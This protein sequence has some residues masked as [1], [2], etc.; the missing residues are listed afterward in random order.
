ME[1]DQGT[2]LRSQ[3]RSQRE[4]ADIIYVGI[5]TVNRDLTYLSKQA[6]VNLKIHVQQKL[7]EQ[8]QKLAKDRLEHCELRF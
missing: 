8:Y 4:I 1:K 7:P 5:G 6:Q 2:E 3:G